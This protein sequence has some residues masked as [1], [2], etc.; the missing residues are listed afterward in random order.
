MPIEKRER[1][2]RDYF[3]DVT[4]FHRL[5]FDGMRFMLM[6]FNALWTLVQDGH[7]RSDHIPSIEVF[8]YREYA[9]NSFQEM[10]VTMDERSIEK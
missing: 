6:H 10:R 3:G 5:R 2:L 1:T 9:E 4:A 8:D 7:V